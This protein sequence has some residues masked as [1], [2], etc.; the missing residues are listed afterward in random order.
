MHR[1]KLTQRLTQKSS[2]TINLISQQM[3]LIIKHNNINSK[4]FGKK[5][6]NL[7]SKHFLFHQILFHFSII[8]IYICHCISQWYEILQ[9]PHEANLLLNAMKPWTEK[10]LLNILTSINN[11]SRLT[12]CT[13]SIDWMQAFCVIEEWESNSTRK[14]RLLHNKAENQTN[15]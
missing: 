2:S 13:Y 14:R 3:V 7:I 1:K 9:I 10:S 6:K 5:Q 8:N 12:I 11:I 4:I 15:Q